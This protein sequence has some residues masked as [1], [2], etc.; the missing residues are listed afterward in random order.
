MKMWRLILY[1]SL[2]LGTRTLCRIGSMK[3]GL[4]SYPHS[5][6]WASSFFSLPGNASKRR[7][8]TAYLSSGAFGN[9]TLAILMLSLLYASWVTSLRRQEMWHTCNSGSFVTASLFF[10]LNLREIFLKLFK[11]TRYVQ[12]FGT[13]AEGNITLGV[14]V[15]RY[16]NFFFSGMEADRNVKVVGRDVAVL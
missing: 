11:S 1:L 2:S 10:F 13:E 4:H 8:K 7:M 14:Q 6:V 12:N 16:P 9:P 15:L 5:T 3:N